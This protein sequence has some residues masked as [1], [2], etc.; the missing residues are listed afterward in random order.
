ML[1]AQR[2]RLVISQDEDN[3]VEKEN[4]QE[5]GEPPQDVPV[6][7]CKA[8]MCTVGAAAGMLHQ[9]LPFVCHKHCSSCNTNCCG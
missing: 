6:V 8:G 4:E 7:R 2:S 9:T 3:E 1:G 5:H